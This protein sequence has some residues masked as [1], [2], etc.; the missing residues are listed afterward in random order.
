MSSKSVLFSAILLICLGFFLLRTI[1]LTSLPI[2]NDESTY[3]RYGIHELNEPDH[4]PYSLLIGKEP[5]D[6]YLYAFVG[7]MIGDLLVGGRLVTIG[8][9]F[10]TLVG[11]YSLTKM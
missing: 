11:I 5:L 10:F 1:N 8:F 2:F 6:P 3:I 9:G 7:T 4:Q